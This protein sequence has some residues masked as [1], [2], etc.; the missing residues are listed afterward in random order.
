MS[1]SAATRIS[2]FRFLGWVA[3]A[4]AGGSASTKPFALT[5]MMDTPELELSAK[6]R[7]V[8]MWNIQHHKS[9]EAF[10]CCLVADAC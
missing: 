2:L 10:G 5:K 8:A 4:R 1:V 6:E 9:S 7:V 3:R